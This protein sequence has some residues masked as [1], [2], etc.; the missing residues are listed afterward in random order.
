VPDWG[1]G[2]GRSEQDLGEGWGIASCDAVGGRF[3]CVYTDGR[4]GVL[5]GRD[6]E[7]FRDA[8]LAGAGAAENFWAVGLGWTARVELLAG[9]DPRAG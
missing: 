5:G 1:L 2:A 7:K 6:G 9:G 3:A 8:L 4:G